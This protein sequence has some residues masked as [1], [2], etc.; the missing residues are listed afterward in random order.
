RA[1]GQ[2]DL[3]ADLLE[4]EVAHLVVAG[5]LRGPVAGEQRERCGNK[6]V[7]AHGATITRHPHLCDRPFQSCLTRVHRLGLAPVA[8]ASRWA[9]Q[10]SMVSRSNNLTEGLGSGIGLSKCSPITAC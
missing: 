3:G 4:V 6:K 7:P 5:L 9:C 8:R 10:R 2:Q 1:S